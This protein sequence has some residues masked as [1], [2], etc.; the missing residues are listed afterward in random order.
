MHTVAETSI[1][2]KRADDLLNKD[3]RNELIR[4]LASDPYGG[5]LVPGLG[6]IRKVRFAAG[7]QGKR[8]AF[9]VIWYVVS[10]DLPV[11]ALLI[12]GKNEQANPSP[13]QR[14]AMLAVVA[15]MKMMAGKG[16]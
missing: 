14:K 12:Y 3:E 15:R 6:G 10:D 2:T 13:E 16:T 1:F 8:G 9:R 11:L 7:G 4:V 5:D